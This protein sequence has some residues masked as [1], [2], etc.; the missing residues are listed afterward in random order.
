ML[1]RLSAFDGSKRFEQM[2]FAQGPVPERKDE[3]NTGM[4]D[5]GT[6]YEVRSFLFKVAEQRLLEKSI[7]D[8][9]V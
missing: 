6:I 3:I 7:T 9:F 2:V 5:Q 1:V 8:V 4:F